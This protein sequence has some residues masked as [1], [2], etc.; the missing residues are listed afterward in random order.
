[1]IA[2][3]LSAALLSTPACPPDWEPDMLPALLRGTAPEAVRKYYR[4]GD[5]EAEDFSTAMQARFHWDQGRDPKWQDFDW[6]YGLP[7]DPEPDCLNVV[8]VVDETLNLGDVM[9]TLQNGGVAVSRRYA[10]VREDGAWKIDDIAMEPEGWRLSEYLA[11]DPAIR[12][13]EPP[14]EDQRR[15]PFGMGLSDGIGQMILNLYEA[16]A[17]DGQAPG[18]YLSPDLQRLL[19][20]D[21][22][23]RE[24][25]LTFDWLDGGDPAPTL[26]ELGGT[27]LNTTGPMGDSP[28]SA[29]PMVWFDRGEV[30]VV[31]RFHLVDHDGYWRIEDV[32]MHPEELSLRA[33]LEGDDDPSC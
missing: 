9:V 30:H 18:R 24:P 10:M 33:V 32:C 15:G 13:H 8:G 16:S 23:R 4:T 3:A 17:R 20:D 28:A 5:L 22:I 21:A 2:L 31:R 27:V 12:R 26:D 19:A 29:S 25:R 11:V 6:L 14:G 1:M 7:Q